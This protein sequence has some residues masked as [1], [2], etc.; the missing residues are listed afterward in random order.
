[1]RNRRLTGFVVVALSIIF[2]ITS[3]LVPV[4]SAKAPYD[5]YA[6]DTVV[7]CFPN[8]VQYNAAMKVIPEFEK[9]TGIKVEVDMLQYMRMHE[10][11]L[12]EMSKPVGDY[13]VISLVC[14]W[15]TEYV[16]KGLLAELA[17][18][19]ANP[20]LA[21]PS[22]D[23]EDIVFPYLGTSGI[24]GGLKGYLPGPGSSTYGIPFG[25]ET[26]ILAYRKDLFDK[27]G[28]TVPDNYDELLDAATFFAEEVEG[29]YGLTMRG[30]AGHQAGHSWLNFA[31]PFGAKV[32]DEFWQ[33]AFQ[34]ENS[35]EALRYMRKF[36]ETGPPG[37]PSFGFDA[38]ANA[39]L[40][41]KAA[42]FLDA[43]AIFGMVPNPELSKVVGKV[44]YAVHPKQKKRAGET[45]GFSIAIPTNS[46]NKEAAFLFIQWLT[47][48]ENT[49]K[50][51]LA[52]GVPFRWSVIND[53]ELREKYPDW[54]VLAEALKYADPDWRPIIPE[55]PE[56]ETEY[57][58]IAVNEVLTGV[59][60]PEE[61]TMAQVEAVRKI[62]KR[63][64][65]YTWEK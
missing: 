65:Y 45:G 26:S 8:H 63:A 41:G 1:M 64:G 58:G 42:M 49:K 17:P 16:V 7:C 51:C 34:K 27:Y 6:G 9:E 47:N 25:S 56:V 50:V 46:Q 11:E 12:L 18:Y 5:R 22:Y 19:F 62:M 10:K 57:L 55:W 35:L 13:D 15:K 38:M 52:G 30:A 29:I 4:A 37:I 24:V 31:G 3:L 44:G 48:K 40:Q 36:V 53:P 14:M 2:L 32:F 61:A 21:D 20:A 23:Q 33:P 54:A 43:T 39:F 60:T 59:K 28:L